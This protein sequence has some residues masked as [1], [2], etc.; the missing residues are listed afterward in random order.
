MS[1][2]DFE[3]L[4]APLAGGLSPIGHQRG[5]SAQAREEL[6]SA[7]VEGRL[8]A[9]SLTS[10]R[11]L[12]EALGISRTP[13]REALV[14]LAQE[15]LVT[16]ERS[17]GVRVNDSK[18]HDILEIF[19]LRRMVEIPA[20]REAVLRFTPRDVRALGREL[21]AMRAHLDDE[22][23]FMQHDRAF[24]RVP[25]EVLGNARLIAILESLRDQTRVRGLSTVGRSRDL[26]AIVAEHQAIYAAA[27][28]GRAAQAAQAM[29]RHL[30]ITEELLRGQVSA[31]VDAEDGGVGGVAPGGRR[32]SVDDELEA[33][34]RD[35]ADGDTQRARRSK[36]HER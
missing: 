12:S 9:G 6:R 20:M 29:E 17:R 15:G 1:G 7:I 21:A 26:R 13:V 8:P 2:V 35:R 31:D 23:T 14:D 19:Q 16:F 4:T 18:G 34:A 5:L 22:R 24:H 30:L 32:G 10:V 3:E 33:G 11:A 28:A 36:P 27:R 25:L